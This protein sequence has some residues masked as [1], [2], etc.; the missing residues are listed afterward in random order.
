MKIDEDLI[1]R[2]LFWMSGLAILVLAI[3]E[4]VWR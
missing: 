2:I 1:L 4:K 3:V